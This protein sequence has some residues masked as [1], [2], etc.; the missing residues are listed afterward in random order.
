MTQQ[1]RHVIICAGLILSLKYNLPLDF[2]NMLYFLLWFKMALTDIENI[3]FVND[4]EIAFGKSMPC[5]I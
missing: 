1:A 3:K 5:V 2:W 4:K